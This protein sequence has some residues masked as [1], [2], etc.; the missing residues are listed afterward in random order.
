MAAVC[1]RGDPHQ[2]FL[3]QYF[4]GLAAL[5]V[6]EIEVGRTSNDSCDAVAWG[7]ILTCATMPAI[8]SRPVLGQ[9]ARSHA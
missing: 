7:P 6:G 3:S 2:W 5:M 9:L 8:W 1:D 4:D